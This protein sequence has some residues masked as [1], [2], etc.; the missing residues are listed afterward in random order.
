MQDGGIMFEYS[1]SVGEGVEGKILKRE[2]DSVELGYFGYIFIRDKGD[3]LAPYQQFLTPITSEMSAPNGG[4]KINSFSDESEN[5]LRSLRVEVFLTALCE[6]LSDQAETSS[7]LTTSNSYLFLTRP[8]SAILPINEND[9]ETEFQVVR[10]EGARL[11]PFMSIT[12]RAEDGNTFRQAVTAACLSMGNIE[13]RLQETVRAGRSG[14]PQG[15]SLSNP[16][17]PPV[18]KI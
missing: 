5:R 15:P 12:V 13:P 4:Q 16:T 14:R 11:K 6:M 8:S 9:K 1:Y 2:G 18:S 10:K 3:I 7:S 17:F